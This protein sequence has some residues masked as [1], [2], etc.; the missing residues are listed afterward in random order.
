MRPH[1]LYVA[2][3]FPPSRASGV[4]RALATV[5]AFVAAGWKVTV[6][7]G[8]REFLYDEIGSIDTSLET[9]IP[10]GVEVLRVPFTFGLTGRDIDVR[11]LGWL[12][13]NYPHVWT[14]LRSETIAMRRYWS[15]IRGTAPEAYGFRDN[16]TSWIEPSVQASRALATRDPL[17]HILATGNPFSSFEIARVVAGLTGCSYSVDYRDPWTIDVFTGRSALDQATEDAEALILAEAAAVFHVNEAIAEAYAAKYPE[18]AG[19]HHVVWNGFDPDSIPASPHLTGDGPV[20]FGILG[21]VNERWPLEPIFEAW[22]DV[23]GKLP[24]GSTLVLGG[25]LGYFDRSRTLL[26]YAL[27]DASL[28]FEYLGP[29][30]KSAVADFYGRLDV[31]VLPVPGGPMV[32][33][34]KVFEAMAVG[35]PIVCVQREDGGARHVLGSHPLAFFARPDVA[36]VTEAMLG[37]AEA[38]RALT[39]A[40]V[41]SARATT[42]AMERSRA[43]MTMVDHVDEL[44]DEARSA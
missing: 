3:W 43:L 20:R 25:H 18:T 15:V 8:S 17:T 24:P 33:S 23:R 12:T 44:V 30:Q 29:V 6:L 35:I 36:E 21:T 22:P 13:A 32:T 41:R 28:G 9:S 14:K 40:A 7:T 38:A 26:E 37:A 4:Y 5:Q 2:F 31:I 10:E 19:K 11:S 16:Y 27:P 39:P 42:E 34:G 1:L